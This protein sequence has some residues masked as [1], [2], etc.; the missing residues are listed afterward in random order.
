MSYFDKFLERMRRLKKMFPNRK[1]TKTSAYDKELAEDDPYFRHMPVW[2]SWPEYK[3]GNKLGKKFA[4]GDAKMRHLYEY[5]QMTRLPQKRTK[6][7]VRKCL[8]LGGFDEGLTDSDT[9]IYD[10]FGEGDYNVLNNFHSKL[11]YIESVFKYMKEQ[12]ER[13]K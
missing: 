7:K 11:E 4:R 3:R 5:M 10:R 8:L 13:K 9:G 1:W 12:R 6:D 2:R